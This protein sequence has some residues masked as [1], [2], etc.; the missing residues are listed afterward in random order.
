MIHNNCGKNV[1]LRLENKQNIA[2]IQIIYDSRIIEVIC[3]YRSKHKSAYSSFSWNARHH[4]LHS[5]AI[6]HHCYVD[7]REP[8]ID[9]FT[10]GSALFKGKHMK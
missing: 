2:Y 6:F 7:L 4:H 8:F 9:Y 1:N 10:A 5:T 3:M